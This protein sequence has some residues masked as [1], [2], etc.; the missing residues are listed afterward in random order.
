MRFNAPDSDEDV[1]GPLE[2]YS[3]SESEDQDQPG[4][5]AKGPRSLLGQ[6][7]KTYVESS[8]SEVEPEEPDSEDEVALGLDEKPAT[9]HFDTFREPSAFPAESSR[10]WKKRSSVMDLDGSLRGGYDEWLRTTE[11]LAIQSAQKMARDR[12]Q[13]LREIATNARTDISS[14]HARRQARN[15]EQMD[16]MMQGIALVDK[17]GKDETQRRFQERQKRLWDD[18]NN[19]IR[20]VERRE[21]E[22]AAAAAAASR[23]RQEEEAARVAAEEKAALA[24]RHEAERLAKEHLAK[25]QAEKEAKAAEQKRLDEEKAAKEEARAKSHKSLSDW[26]FW[27]EKQQW[28]KKEV[29]E[30]VKGDKNLR[31]SL[32]QGMRLM[33]R[34]LGQV[35]NTQEGVV[36]VTNDIHKILC[37]QLQSPPSCSSAIHLPAPLSYSYLLSHLSK[38]LIKQAESEVSA[39]SEA[40]FPLAR[41]VIGLLLRGHAALG[42]IFFARLVKKCPW[43]VPHYPGRRKPREEFEKSTGRGVDESLADYIARMVGITTLYFAIL[44]TPIATIIPT[45]PAQPTPEQLGTLINPPFRAPAAWSWLALVLRDP[46]RG[47]EPTASMITMW[48]DIIGAEAVRLWGRPQVHKLF[49]LISQGVRDGRIK[50]DSEAA[51]QKLGLVMEQAGSIEHPKGRQWT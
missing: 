5:E 31:T 17:E 30:P 19:A 50:G 43:V 22:V 37:E 27:V 40:A 48:M 39:K 2:S 16:R 10:A 41:V 1:Y 18:I 45:L 36:R 7:I 15:E 6:L 24:R 21:A 51:R 11:R 3:D 34:G 33:T 23:K 9:G 46:L 49:A 20:E 32:R 35:V 38:A 13:S 8:E 14:A 25:Q 28:M 4:L 47:L 12:R 44:Q 42:E 29:I 26:K